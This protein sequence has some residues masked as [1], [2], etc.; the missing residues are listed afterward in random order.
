MRA[1]A[2]AS[3]RWKRKRML[4]KTEGYWGAKKRHVRRMKEALMKSGKYAYFDRKKRKSNLRMLWITRIN[5]AAR[6][7]GVRYSDLMKALK[8]ANIQINRK[9]LAEMAFSDLESF[10]RLVELARKYIKQTA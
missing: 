1:R 10:G 3:R 9:E 4:K 7:N 5:A 6:L 8:D 2:G